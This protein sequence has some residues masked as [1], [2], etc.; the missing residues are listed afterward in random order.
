MAMEEV[1]CEVELCMT[2]FERGEVARLTGSKGAE[3]SLCVSS[4][5]RRGQPLFLACLRW[6]IT[7]GE[8]KVAKY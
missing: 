2:D 1:R 8:R 6:G 3:L 4:H 7:F 5:V